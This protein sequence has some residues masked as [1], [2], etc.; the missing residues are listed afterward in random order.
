MFYA[1]YII[2]QL[3]RRKIEEVNIEGT[4]NVLRG[5]VYFDP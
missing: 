2:L 1:V 3:N 5:M 4:K